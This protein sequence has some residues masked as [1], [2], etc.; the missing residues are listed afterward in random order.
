[1]RGRA[2]VTVA[3]FSDSEA[4][5]GTE[6]AL[7]QLLGGLD[8]A[9]WRPVLFHADSPGA[10][11]LAGEARALDVPTYGIAAGRRDSGVLPSE[12]S[13][14]RNLQVA[15]GIAS[16]APIARAL[17]RERASVF[18]A[19]QIWS[20]SCRYGIVAAALARVRARIATAQLFVEM[21]PLLGIDLQHALLTRCL[22]RHVA[23][24]RFVA[25]R[26]RDRF[27]VPPGKIV[28]IPNAATMGATARPAPRSELARD[29]GGPVVL[30]V[31][32]LDGQK[33]IT[34]LLDAVATLPNASFAIAG[35]GPNRAALEQRAA[36]LG[37]SDRV[38]FLGHR[39]DVPALLAAADLFVLPS[40][41][42]GLPLSVLEAMAAGVPVVATAI[43][44]TDEVVRDGETGTLVPPANSEAL[45]AAIGR[46]LADRDRA[47]RLALA[48]RSLVAR[49]YSVASMVGSVSRLYDE[50]LAR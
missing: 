35:D 37:V 43:G 7:L 47:S 1:V 2:P 32:R 25:S 41:Y 50:L 33:G 21:P 13:E 22:H 20:L 30:T 45:A 10:S 26:L 49:E 31:A 23:V 3:H 17:R 34:H 44:G 40:L 28:V 29:V 38:R 11:Q 15:R 36:T 14:S 42:E 27:H 24:S 9:R 6:R 5:G 19:H 8:R 16:M 48:A 12:R 46:A 4:F 39:H 18:H